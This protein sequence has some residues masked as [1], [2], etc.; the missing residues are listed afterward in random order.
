MLSL[1]L[2]SS[3]LPVLMGIGVILGMNKY[4]DWKYSPRGVS[5]SY[6]ASV[7]LLFALFLSLV[8]SE[9][10]SKVTKTNALMTEQANSMR[11]LL[12]L[13]EPLGPDSIRVVRAVK[14]Y[15]STLKEQEVNDDMLAKKG[16]AS[17][18][19]QS[20]SK[21]TFEEFYK[22]AADNDYFKGH[23]NMQSAFYTELESIREAW[24]E[25]REMRKQHISITKMAVLY[26][27]GLFTQIA[28][29]FSHIGN[30]NALRATTLLFSLAFASAIALLAYI[31]NPHLTSYLVQIDV[32][33]DIR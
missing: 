17:Y 16:F 3:L 21:K 7:A 12:R 6:F 9:V 27:F 14:N 13:T 5:P 33:E 15:I 24:F 2:L 20:F 32:L 11:A 23:P 25:R 19:I 10:W 26:I 18:K 30:K 28:I 29:A 22:L 1:K 4:S 8:F 31:D